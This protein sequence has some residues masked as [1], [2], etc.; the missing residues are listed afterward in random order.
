MKDF[1]LSRNVYRGAN[2]YDP[3]LCMY[4]IFPKYVSW[5]KYNIASKCIELCYSFLRDFF[6]SVF[7]LR[8]FNNV[9]IL[10]YHNSIF[11]PSYDKQCFSVHVMEGIIKQK[12]KSECG[13]RQIPI[14]LTC[15]KEK[16]TGNLRKGNR[17]IVLKQHPFHFVSVLTLKIQ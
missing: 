2:C 1:N 17:I 14:F 10:S 7:T 16:K 12:A 13:A 8:N 5:A 6:Q 3:F 4:G 15:K 9:W 11:Y